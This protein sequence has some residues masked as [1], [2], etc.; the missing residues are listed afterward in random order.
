[1]TPDDNMV[2]FEEA[3]PG[4]TPFGSTGDSGGAADDPPSDPPA[5]PPSDPD[6]VAP[7]DGGDGGAPPPDPDPN[8]GAGEPPATDPEWVARGFAPE[9]FTEK[10][11]QT[12][13]SLETRFSQTR[14]VTEP[15]LEEP[16]APPPPVPLRPGVDGGEIDTE[17]KLYS[18]A[19]RAP[20]DAAMFALENRERLNDEQFELVMNNWFA[21]NPT[22]YMQQV[23]AW[24]NEIQEER[25]REQQAEKDAHYLNTIRDTG[26]EQAV[27][28]LPMIA[29]YRAELAAFMEENPHLNTWVEGLST[30]AQVK[31]ALHS[32]FYQMAGPK[33]AQQILESQVATS[34]AAT[35]AAEAKAAEEAAAAEQ[36][37]K[38]QSTRRSTAKPPDDEQAYGDAIR[39]R[40]L[41][42]I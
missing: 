42:S 32:I 26:I 17:E 34:V 37:T 27:A 3:F 21:S 8:A 4:V 13:R 25:Y 40:I 23:M 33:L 29:D 18:Y 16:P 38:A 28:E 20:R 5:D 14:P 9:D 11:W 19:Q 7:A 36:T 30:A 6:P 41:K 10:G 22:Q 39:E 24:N 1:M 15:A 31:S 35:A 2:S 12:Y